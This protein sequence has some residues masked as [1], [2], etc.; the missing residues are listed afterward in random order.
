MLGYVGVDFVV[1]V[2]SD[3]IEKQVGMIVSLARP[4][5]DAGSSLASGVRTA[6]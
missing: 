5:S 4:G 1:P 6:V 3:T 2:W